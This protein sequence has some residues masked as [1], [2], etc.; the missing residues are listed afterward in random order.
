MKSMGVLI[1]KEV[2]DYIRSKKF[3]VLLLIVLCTSVASLYSALTTLRHNPPSPDSA[4]ASFFFLQVFTHSDGTLPPFHVFI[5]FLGPLLG[6]CLGFD[7]INA[8][9][10][11]RSL[12]RILAQPIARDGLL[13]AKFIGALIILVFIFASL[14]CMTVGLAVFW[15]GL[16]PSFHECL[17]LGLFLFVTVAYVGFWLNLALLFSVLWKHPATSA[18]VSIAVWLFF[19]VFYPMIIGVIAKGMAPGMYASNQEIQSFQNFILS[20]MRLAPNQLYED[21]T[22]VLLMPKV[23]SL[24]PLSMEQMQGAIPTALP[25]WESVKVVWTQVTALIASTVICFACSYFVF[26]RREIRA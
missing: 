19:M 22:L 24:S 8:E 2:S 18:L 23:R 6:I 7:A 21:G 20:I 14:I 3:I 26:M 10:T 16:T 12:T 17:R 25:V 11:N 4:Q 13:N 9:Y 15:T 1:D 5:S